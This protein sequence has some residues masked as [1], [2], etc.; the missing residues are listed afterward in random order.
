MTSGFVG[1]R[2][3]TGPKLLTR[4]AGQPGIVGGYSKTTVL[5]LR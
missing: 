1:M 3:R 4:G 5:L 2:S